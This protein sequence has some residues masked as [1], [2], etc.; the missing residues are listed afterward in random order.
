[1]GSALVMERDPGTLETL[2]QAIRALGLEIVR[3][4]DP[5]EALARLE[6]GAF[7]VGFFE[8]ELAYVGEPSLMQELRRRGITMP[9]F[10]ISRDTRTAHVAALLRGGARELLFKPVML[11]G[12]DDRIAKTVVGVRPGPYPAPARA[13]PSMAPGL[14][15]SSMPP[16]GSAF[17]LPSM[18]VPPAGFSMPPSAPAAVSVSY[19]PTAMPPASFGASSGSLPPMP[20]PPVEDAL[21]VARKPFAGVEAAPLPGV[22]SQSPT[23]APTMPS[24]AP[25]S[26]FKDVLL[27]DDHPNVHVRFR[28]LAGE[29]VEV[30]ASTDP[31]AA[32][33]LARVSNYRLIVVDT[34]IPG[35]DSLSIV[36]QLAAIQPQAV[37]IA[38]A[39]RGESEHSLLRSPK[40]ISTLTKP[41]DP[42]ALETLLFRYLERQDAIVVDNEVLRLMPCGDDEERRDRSLRRAQSMFDAI[43][44]S[45][46]EACFDR[47]VADLLALP[48]DPKR[49]TRFVLALT[50]AARKRGL[51]LHVVGTPELKAIMRS[52]QDTA[53]VVVHNT[54]DEARSAP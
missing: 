45:M 15:G 34:E 51:A 27:I 35:A 26:G 46:A 37:F 53:D 3:A 33:A 36:M 49:A 39:V 6:G 52:F 20:L 18:S 32:L 28:A 8:D 38:L 31:S 19:P 22:P 21:G 23:A 7:D 29:R 16:G 1:M 30:D 5:S 10:A 24:M 13:M 4:S 11:N 48:A 44:R 40:V 41:F 2:E 17:S 50:E 43:T 14:L 25:A 12:L 42:G 54:L 47:I 9:V